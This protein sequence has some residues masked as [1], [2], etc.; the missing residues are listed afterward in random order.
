MA[1]KVGQGSGPFLINFK[2]PQKGAKH[3]VY[4]H[5]NGEPYKIKNI[6]SIRIA[7]SP[8]FPG[9]KVRVLFRQN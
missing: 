5:I 9:G 6:K 2:K 7:P 8:Q 3:S 4:I 1:K